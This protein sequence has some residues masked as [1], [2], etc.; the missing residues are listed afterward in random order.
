MTRTASRGAKLLGVVP[1][2]YEDSARVAN[3][4]SQ[5]E[6]LGVAAKRADLFH[7]EESYWLGPSPLMLL[8]TPFKI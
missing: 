8:S 2:P 3:G 4:A 5:Q 7:S 6:H 1:A